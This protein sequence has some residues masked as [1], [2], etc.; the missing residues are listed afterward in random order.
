[1]SDSVI[2]LAVAYQKVESITVRVVSAVFELRQDTIARSNNKISILIVP[3]LR[4]N[5]D[6]RLFG[7]Q[8]LYDHKFPLLGSPYAV[9]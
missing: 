5:K 7:G 4:H 2:R 9:Y 6:K 3:I 8:D 1:M